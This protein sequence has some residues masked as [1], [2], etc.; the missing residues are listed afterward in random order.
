[1]DRIKEAF[2]AE[3]VMASLVHFYVSKQWLNKL[4][5]FAEPGT[6]YSLNLDLRTT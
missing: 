6:V 1:M 2:A 5:N 3:R 4:E